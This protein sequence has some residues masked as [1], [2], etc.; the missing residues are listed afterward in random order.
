MDCHFGSKS[1]QY[2]ST[3]ILANL[4]KLN[5]GILNEKSLTFFGLEKQQNLIKIMIGVMNEHQSDPLLLKN[6]LSILKLFDFTKI[7]LVNGNYFPRKLL[8]YL[9]V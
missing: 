1:I 6:G 5:D 2:S 8:M 3:A 7:K 9:Y 4:F